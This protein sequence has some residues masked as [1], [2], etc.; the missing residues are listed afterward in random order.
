MTRPAPEQPIPSADQPHPLERL[1][2]QERAVF[3]VLAANAGRVV[4]R[5]ELA[6]RA[7]LADLSTRR[8][9]SLI[10]GIRRG[11]G[12]DRVRTVRRRGWMLLT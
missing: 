9:D 10:V 2:A 3:D 8:C 4:S 7:G 6:R 5:Q 11:V 1:T 12:P